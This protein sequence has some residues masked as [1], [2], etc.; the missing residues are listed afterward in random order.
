MLAAAAYAAQL[1]QFVPLAERVIEQSR[2]RVLLGGDVPAGQK[3]LSIFEPH[4]DVI[5]K[6]QRE[7]L[8][9]H[10]VLFTG[11]KSNLVLDCAILRGN[12]ADATLFIPAIER[13]EKQFGH[14]P[15]QAATDAGFAS[16]ANARDT[17]QKGVRDVVLAAPK[18][19]DV[20][21]M[22]PD[23]KTYKRLRNWRSGI[24]GIISAVKRAFGLTRCTWSGFG[25]FQAY[26]QLAVLAFNLQTLAR[27]LLT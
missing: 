25:S 7:I 20:P 8:Y 10:K 5:K 21:E 11:G 15:I 22:R 1:E 27:H 17:R 16:K 24:E 14:A 4:T 18:D 9:G 6:G 3:I 26:V 13:H 12:P 23:S 19:K 2:R